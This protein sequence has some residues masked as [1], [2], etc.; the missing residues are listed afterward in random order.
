MAREHLD[1]SIENLDKNPKKLALLIGQTVTVTEKVDGTKLTLIRNGEPWDADVRKN[2]IVAY[3]SNIIG[4]DDFVGLTHVH[5]QSISQYSTGISQY[6]FVWDGLRKANANL[7]NIPKNTEFFVEFVMRKGTL[8]RQYEVYHK[9]LLIAHSPTRYTVRA[10]KVF[11]TPSTFDTSRLDVYAQALGILSPRVIYHGQLKDLLKSSTPNGMLQDLK[12]HFLNLPSQFGGK[13]EGVVLEFNSGEVFK[14]VQDDQYDKAT[15]AANKAAFEPENPTSY[16]DSVRSHAEKHVNTLDATQPVDKNIAKLSIA[17][18]GGKELSLDPNRKSIN[19]KDDVFLTAKNILMRRAPGN[20]GALFLGRFSPLTIAHHKIIQNAL[21]TYDTVTVNV[22]KAKIDDKNPF[23]VEIQEKMLKACF[24][25][26]IEVI[27]ST[28]GNLAT[29]LQKTKNMVNVV[30]AGSDR[31]DGYTDQLKRDKDI[32]V[33]EIPRTDE[34]SGTLVRKYLRE[35]NKA[36]FQK[37]VPHEVAAMYDEL[38][39]IIDGVE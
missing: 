39:K 1:I 28:T 12:Q 29:I 4:S 3:K 23:P 37:Y 7:K 15:R 22:V 14:I 24:G 9:M 21:S 5:N 35:G 31:V 25:N 19:A 17:V 13:M 18:Y 36:M 26:R 6:K 20:N 8:T 2:W 33:V 30:L 32:R 11:S 16:W 27:I 10:G 34:V 38:K